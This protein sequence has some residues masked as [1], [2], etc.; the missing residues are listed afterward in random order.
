MGSVESIHLNPFACCCI[1][2]CISYRHIVHSYLVF[3]ESPRMCLTIC[4]ILETAAG[5][6]IIAVVYPIRCFAP[7]HPFLSSID[8]IE[9]Q[10]QFCFGESITTEVTSLKTLPINITRNSPACN[11]A[12]IDLTLSFDD[13]NGTTFSKFMHS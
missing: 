4:Y 1:A 9:V 7:F 6:N 11:Q 2:K 13:D 5:N 12:S 3:I 10:E 8:V